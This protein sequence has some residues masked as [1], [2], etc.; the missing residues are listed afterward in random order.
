MKKKIDVFTGWLEIISIAEA[1]YQDIRE[2]DFSEESHVTDIT[3][4]ST[5][6]KQSLFS[7]IPSINI[8]H[9]YLETLSQVFERN[10]NYYANTQEENF[11]II[12]GSPILNIQINGKNIP[13]NDDIP[14]ALGEITSASEIILIPVLLIIIRRMYEKCV[15]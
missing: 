1:S 4:N 2:D 10:I 12:G 5:T 8:D 3:N 14:S 9:G 11:Y 6:R 13:N 7:I 15:C